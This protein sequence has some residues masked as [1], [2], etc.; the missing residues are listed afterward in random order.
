MGCLDQVGSEEGMCD[1]TEGTGSS[2]S[3]VSG[4]SQGCWSLPLE[5]EW[6]EALQSPCPAELQLFCEGVLLESN[7]YELQNLGTSSA[8]YHV[9]GRLLRVDDGPSTKAFH[10]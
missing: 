7:W 1:Y 10:V 5:R 3:S 8:R 2:G 4:D 9:K 6:K